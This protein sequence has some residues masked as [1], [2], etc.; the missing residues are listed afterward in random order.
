MLIIFVSTTVI[1]CSIS[2]SCAGEDIFSKKGVCMLVCVCLPERN[3][4]K[5]GFTDPKDKRKLGGLYDISLS[6]LGRR[7]TYSQAVLLR[8]EGWCQIFP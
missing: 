6:N 5:T 8:I 7:I 4:E 3:Y 2:E 1:L